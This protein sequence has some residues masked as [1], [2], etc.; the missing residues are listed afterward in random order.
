MLAGAMIGTIGNLAQNQQNQQNTLMLAEKNYQ[1]G[2]QAADN[3]MERTLKLYNEIDSPEAKVRQLQK[4]GLS[5]G[6]LLSGGGVSGS[7]AAGPQ[8][9]GT[10]GMNPIPMKLNPMEGALMGA[11]IEKIKAET[12]NINEDTI[13]VNLDN[14]GK[15]IENDIKTLNRAGVEKQNEILEQNLEALKRENRIGNETEQNKIEGLRAQYQTAITT[16]GKELVEL[17]YKEEQITADIARINAATSV[18]EARAAYTDLEKTIHKNQNLI[19]LDDNDEEGTGW[20]TYKRT[21]KR[22]REISE[23]IGGLV[24]GTTKM[25]GALKGM[26][27]VTTTTTRNGNTT[28]STT[29]RN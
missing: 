21:S 27:T 17:G 9:T 6:L 1:Y 23:T 25:I 5:P 8:G 28:T 2:E 12:N 13:G 29:K 10:S 16:L 3:A 15:T 24:D 18:D 19:Y 7:T 4:A 14:I 22:I 26:P 20:N 11:Q